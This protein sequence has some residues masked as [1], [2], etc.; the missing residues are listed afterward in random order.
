MSKFTYILNR[1]QEPSTWA[2]IAALGMLVGIPHG[3]LDAVSQIISGVGALAA[4]LIKDPGH[5]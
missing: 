2:G 4:V 3:T 1:L 5:A